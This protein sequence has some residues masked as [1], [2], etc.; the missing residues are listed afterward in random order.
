[1]ASPYLT[2][3]AGL[4]QSPEVVG[5]ERQ[6][7]LAD[8]LTS[9]AFQSPQGQMISGQYVKPA[10]TQQL[11]PL[12]SALL[13]TSMNKNLDEKQ[14]QMAAALRN[15][16]TTGIDQY[17]KIKA[18]QGPAAANA[19][20]AKSNVS[21]LRSA[22]LKE[23]FAPPI[24]AGIEDTLLDPNTY[25]PIFIGA[26]KLPAGLDVAASLIP[27][28]PRNRAEWTPQ[29]QKMVENKVLELEKAKAAVTHINLPSEGERKAGTMVNILDKNLKQM[30]NALGVDP[31]SVKPNVPASI[32]ESITGPNLLTRG[33]K[34]AQRQIIEDSQLDVLDAALTLRTGAAYTREQLN[35]MRDT[36]FPGLLDKP[37]AIEAKKQRLQTLIDSAYISAGRATPPRVSQPYQ[38]PVAPNAN[39]QLNIPITKPKFLG[40][41]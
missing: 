34:P 3:Q 10:T 5:L 35:A 25:Q 26:G 9:Q 38:A 28:L 21:A 40:F 39:Q 33:M 24:K 15:E 12:L 20:L 17:Q 31:S 29:Q 41:E 32:V 27:G 22:G 19:Y 23:M 30:Q 8:L 16:E 4:I 6:R 36:Y 37:P 7:K 14:L 11:Q 13:A 1:M 18:E 2:E